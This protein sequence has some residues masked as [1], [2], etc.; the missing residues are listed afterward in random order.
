M[1]QKQ[2]IYWVFRA[3]RIEDNPS[4]FYAMKLAR[5]HDAYLSIKFFVWP[6]FESNNLRNM[7]FLLHGLLE[8]AKKAKK[9]NIPLTIIQRI[10]HEYFEEKIKEDNIIAVISD[11][12]VLNEVLSEQRQVKAVCKQNGASFGVLNTAMVVPVE[13]ASIKLEFAARTIRKK[14]HEKVN[15]YIT[16]LPKLTPL[17]QK[18]F[19]TLNQNQVEDILNLPHWKQLS[20]SELVAGEDAANKQLD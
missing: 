11:Q 5:K 14:I 19:D 13:E 15:D 6:V 20:L 9:L 2:I 4:L 7:H 12:H 16:M 1:K 18:L 17:D 10:P 8:M 3:I